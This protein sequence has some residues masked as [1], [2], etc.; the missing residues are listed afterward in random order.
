MYYL[1]HRTIEKID[2]D[3]ASCIEQENPHRSQQQ[4]ERPSN[5]AKSPQPQDNQNKQDDI[6]YQPDQEEQETTEPA[7]EN[8]FSKGIKVVGN[9][10]SS[11][12]QG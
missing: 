1:G 3:L 10:L 8:M 6:Q 4:E 9:I 5:K 2:I 7:N 11:L 12:F